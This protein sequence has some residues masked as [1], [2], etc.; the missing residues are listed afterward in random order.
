MTATE[1]DDKGRVVIPADIRRQLGLDAGAHVSVE[2]RGDEVVLRRR[3]PMREA[4]AKL[5]AAMA[6]I[7]KEARR[8]RPDTMAAKDMWTEKLPARYR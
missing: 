6:A 7:P 3:L 4:L 1:V 5:K 8:R 2:V